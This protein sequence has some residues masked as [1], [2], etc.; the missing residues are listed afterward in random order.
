[1]IKYID[2]DQI[3]VSFYS[4]SYKTNVSY[5]RYYFYLLFFV[6]EYHRS[7]HNRVHICSNKFV[8]GS[9]RIILSNS[10]RGFS[11][12]D[13]I[14]KKVLLQHNQHCMEIRTNIKVYNLEYIIHLLYAVFKF[15]FFLS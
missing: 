12:F 5:F 1:M 7:Y 2:K 4:F 9:I 15:V 10:T 8:D 14:F 13:F 11:S 6:D 3:I